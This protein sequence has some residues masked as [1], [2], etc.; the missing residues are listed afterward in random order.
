M[1][2]N[3]IKFLMAETGIRQIDLA[4]ALNKPP[5]MIHH[6]IHGRSRHPVIVRELARRLGVSEEDIIDAH[7]ASTAA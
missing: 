3:E 6:V 1:T 4:R 5:A 2:P 7:N